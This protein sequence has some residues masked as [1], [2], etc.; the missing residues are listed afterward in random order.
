VGEL[1]FQAMGGT[2][3][4]GIVCLTGVSPVG[5]R[6]DVDAGS[7]N[8]EIVLENDVVIGSVNAN[9]AHYAM[10]AD[11]LARADLDWL[12][13]LITRRVPLE[14]WRAA[15]AAEPHDVKIVISLGE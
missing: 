1:V 15:F 5:R 13:R 7:I 12:E 10:A 9:L 3:E 2:A 11:A 6:L 4:F 8:R 14:H